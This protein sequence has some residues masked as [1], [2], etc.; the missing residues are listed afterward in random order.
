[1]TAK[2]QADVT[3]VP[4]KKRTAP[5]AQYAT[6]S[7]FKELTETLGSLTEV[8]LKMSEK[9]S[10]PPKEQTPE[11]VKLDKEV[12]SA[13]ADSTSTTVNPAWMEKAQAIVGEALDHCEVLYPRNGGVLFTLV[14][15]KEHSNASQDYMDRYKVDRRTKEIGNEGI[16]G[17]ENWCK[18]VAQNLKRK[19]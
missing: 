11:E 2:K 19:R 7:Q 15:K 10:N 9:L 8:V 17:V 12:K 1:M 6:A 18:L 16:E 13:V 3:P 14:I 5:K 4:S